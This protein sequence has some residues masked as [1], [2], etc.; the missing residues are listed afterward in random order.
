MNVIL[1]RFARGAVTGTLSRDPRMALQV[2]S[3]VKESKKR[4]FLLQIGMACRARWGLKLE[5]V[6]H[7]D[8]CTPM[9]EWPLQ[10]ARDLGQKETH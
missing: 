2:A 10:P 4:H 8:R 9:S 5:K 1:M 7:E 6:E 3:A